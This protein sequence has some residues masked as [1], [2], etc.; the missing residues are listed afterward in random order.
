MSE[1]LERVIGLG[2]I[3]GAGLALAV[4]GLGWLPPVSNPF[5]QDPHTVAAP[6]PVR[7]P[8]RRAPTPRHS[9]GPPWPVAY[10]AN[11]L[12]ELRACA[13]RLGW[14]P[15]MPTQ[16]A[17][18]ATFEEAYTTSGVL[19]AVV[20]PYFVEEALRPIPSREGPTAVTRV[21]LSNGQSGTWW[22]VPGEGGGY[23][24]L[25]L[26]VGSRYIRLA[27]ANKV[28]TLDPLAT[29]F[30]PISTIRPA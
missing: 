5:G 9:Q 7:V 12:G 2:L 27:G 25:N 14:K 10:S 29:S 21:T 3:V 20:G 6:A 22:W 26:Q 30:A 4:I 8:R 15:W 23:Y 24:R 28:S 1:R 19:C 16:S 13:R 18:P 11:G 17:A